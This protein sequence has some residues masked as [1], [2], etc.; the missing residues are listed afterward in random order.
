MQRLKLKPVEGIAVWEHRIK[1]YL[2]DTG[3]AT[4]EEIMRYLG[5]K[6]RIIKHLTKMMKEKQIE[7]DRERK[8]EIVWKL[9]YKYELSEKL[10]GK[11]WEK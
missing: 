11:R 1:K 9:A 5:T 6:N 2:H 10:D 8:D 3:G 4:E 7:P